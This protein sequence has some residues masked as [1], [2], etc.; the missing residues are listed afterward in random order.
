MP[1]LS[2]SISEVYESMRCYEEIK[3][4]S[5]LV[6][7]EIVK[8]SCKCFLLSQTSFCTMHTCTEQKGATEIRREVPNFHQEMDALCGCRSEFFPHSALNSTL[9]LWQQHS[10]SNFNLF[11]YKL[12]LLGSIHHLCRPVY[13]FWHK[14]LHLQWLNNVYSIGWRESVLFKKGMFPNIIIS[15][16]RESRGNPYCRLSYNPFPLTKNAC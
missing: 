6:I 1:L 7:A 2:H 10:K 5:L 8:Q 9:F 12:Q 4:V 14:V 13:I 15:V 11:L 16:N 3:Q